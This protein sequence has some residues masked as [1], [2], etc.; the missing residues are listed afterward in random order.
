MALSR[1]PRKAAQYGFPVNYSAH[2]FSGDLL[3]SGCL[4]RRGRQPDEA[5][6]GLQA[7]QRVTACRPPAAVIGSPSWKSAPSKR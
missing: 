3:G 1:A 7:G 4:V 2:V 5:D 6:E